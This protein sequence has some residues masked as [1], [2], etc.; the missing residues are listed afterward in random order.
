VSLEDE[1][2]T[3]YANRLWRCL[4]RVA[5]HSLPWAHRAI[6]TFI[7]RQA[8][9]RAERLHARRRRDLLT[10]D[11]HLETALAFSGRLE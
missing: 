10:M 11:E 6:G 8:Q 2:M 7:L 4:G 9:R 1:I 3:V 5:G